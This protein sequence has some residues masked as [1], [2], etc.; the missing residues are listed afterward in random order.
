MNFFLRQYNTLS[1]FCQFSSGN[2]ITVFNWLLTTLTVHTPFSPFFFWEIKHMRQ[3][4][5]E[6]KTCVYS[7]GATVCCNERPWALLIILHTRRDSDNPSVPFQFSFFLQTSSC[8]QGDT[9]GLLDGGEARNLSPKFFQRHT[10]HRDS[11]EP[12]KYCDFVPRWQN[13]RT[14]G[15]KFLFA[16]W[17][18]QAE[19][20][21]FDQI[22]TAES[23]LEG[24]PHAKR[25]ENYNY[26]LKK[27]K[28]NESSI[29]VQM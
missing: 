10:A 23:C 13:R 16:M 15:Q 25:W 8:I 21:G 24:A 17:E 5:V 26:F 29:I 12:S 9:V 20:E 27:L 18:I 6:H 19:S 3:M 7:E 22:D 1:F 11:A 2:E 4:T 28:E 14:V